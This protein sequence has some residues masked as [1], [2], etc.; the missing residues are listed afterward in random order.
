MDMPTGSP[1]GN[2]AI[3][4]RPSS[5]RQHMRELIGRQAPGRC[6]F[7]LG[8]PHPDS[9][10]IL[11]RYFGTREEEELRQKLGDNVR[12]ICPQF[13]KDAYRDPAGRALFDAGLDR[14]KHGSVGPLADCASVQEVERFPWPN[15]DYLDFESCLRDLRAAGDVVPAQRVLDLL[16]S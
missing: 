10:P 6:G 12:W 8:K 2:A 15:P 14:E 4:F 1:R 13:Y 9:W 5:T 3:Q 11:H 7:W 16:F